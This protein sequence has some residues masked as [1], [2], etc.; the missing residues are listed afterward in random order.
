MEKARL[1]DSGSDGVGGKKED[2]DKD[3]GPG[4]YDGV[5]VFGLLM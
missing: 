3:G 5:G 2:E 1:G 4:E